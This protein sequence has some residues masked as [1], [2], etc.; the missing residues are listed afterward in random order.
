MK[1]V[2]SRK[3]EGANFAL[4]IAENDAK[5]STSGQTC[6]QRL[7]CGDIEREEVTAGGDIFGDQGSLC[8]V[9][10]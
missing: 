4:F 10:S 9:K 5:I 1:I 6:G 3:N 7:F 2:P 8:F